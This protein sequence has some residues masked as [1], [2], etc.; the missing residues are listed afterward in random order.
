MVGE[1]RLADA[2]DRFYTTDVFLHTWDLAT[3]VG[4][5]PQLDTDFAAQVYSGMQG[6]ETCSGLRDSTVRRCRYPPTPTPSPGSRASSDATRPGGQ[7]GETDTASP[8]NTTFSQLP[9]R[10]QLPH[11]KL[12]AC[13]HRKVSASGAR[14]SS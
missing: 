9:Q 4:R 1:L 5:D 13:P 8:A 12:T 3:A 14:S 2:I 11:S 7:S 6:I 10:N